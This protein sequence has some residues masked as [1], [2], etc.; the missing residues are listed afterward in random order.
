[1]MDSNSNA[2]TPGEIFAQWSAIRDGSDGEL[3][4]IDMGLIRETMRLLTKVNPVDKKMVLKDGIVEMYSNIEGFSTA[5]SAMK[6]LI[7][8]DTS[9]SGDRFRAAEGRQ[10]QQ[11]ASLTSNIGSDVATDMNAIIPYASTPDILQQTSTNCMERIA[12]IDE[13]ISKI[14]VSI[15][16]GLSGSSSASTAQIDKLKES[17][18]ALQLTKQ[19]ISN[20]LDIVQGLQNQNNRDANFKSFLDANILRQTTNANN[21]NKLN[22]TML[23]IEIILLQ[24]ASFY[25]E[26]EFNQ[27]CEV[28][29]KAVD[30]SI[31]SVELKQQI[32][33]WLKEN[34][35]DI[36]SRMQDAATTSLQVTAGVG[37]ASAVTGIS[38]PGFVEVTRRGIELGSAGMQGPFTRPTILGRVITIGRQVIGAAVNLGLAGARVVARALPFSPRVC[39]LLGTSYGIWRSLNEEDRANLRGMA[40]RGATNVGNAANSAY[41]LGNEF[42][43]YLIQ[44]GFNVTDEE[45]DDIISIASAESSAAQSA[46]S[47]AASNSST[48]MTAAS[49]RSVFSNASSKSSQLFEHLASA[50][51]AEEFIKRL[52]EEEARLGASGVLDNDIA[53]EA[54]MAAASAVSGQGQGNLAGNEF[55]FDRLGSPALSDL[56]QSQSWSRT[57]SPAY[58]AVATNSRGNSRGNSQNDSDSEEEIE[59]G[60]SSSSSARNNSG[61]DAPEKMAVGMSSSSSARNNSGMAAP[62][63]MANLLTGDEMNEENKGGRRKSRRRIG[64]LQTKKRQ[65][66]LRRRKTYK[67]K[68]MRRRTLKRRRPVRRPLRQA[69]RRSLK[70]QRRLRRRQTRR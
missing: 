53:D 55:V 43:E 33:L 11:L 58:G 15:L 47:S 42:H 60:M 52:T 22:A 21:R 5:L 7:S 57:G 9:M 10:V 50:P 35:P 27:V 59:V 23:R 44:R 25:S 63:E 24:K 16:Q 51:S 18:V 28:M 67:K 68:H 20:L 38:L 61:M 6:T 69:K 26:E 31:A 37:V 30:N 34:I 66:R 4:Y 49:V 12:A 41:N 19:Y 3:G 46:E 14:N 54:T 32:I 48:V 17:R 1:M 29:I 45:M 2:I 8:L 56:S 70:K 13:Q 39:L 62:E 40:S 36:L 65:Y 64:K